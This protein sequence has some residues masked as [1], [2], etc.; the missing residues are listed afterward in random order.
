[1]TA[2]H[3]VTPDASN[4]VRARS[5][6]KQHA[7]A[8]APNFAP[9][10]QAQGKKLMAPTACVNFHPFAKMLKEWETGVP[11]DCGKNWT[12]ETIEAAVEKGMHKSATTPESIE[13]IAEDVAYQVKSGYAE[14]ISWEDLSRLRPA[15]LKVSPLAVVP[16]RN[17]RGRMILDLSF[18]V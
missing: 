15:N 16:Q 10:V 18:A 8:D 7:M 5:G 12:W 2:N 13:L 3:T 17:R 9:M 1:M 14:I 4:P 6:P 11:V